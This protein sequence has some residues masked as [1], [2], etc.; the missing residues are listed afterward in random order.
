MMLQQDKPDDYVVGTGKDYSVRE[1][2]EAAFKY[3]GIFVTW[4]NSGDDEIGVNTA[5]GQVIVKIDPRY[6]RPTEV[7]L[8]RSKAEKAEKKFWDGNRRLD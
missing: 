1:F 7:N 8:L 3:K 6:F 4:K 2:I 5:N